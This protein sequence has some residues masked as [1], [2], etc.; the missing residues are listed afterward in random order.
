MM[1]N[2]RASGLKLDFYTL[3]FMVEV[4]FNFVK[5]FAMAC[6]GPRPG[7]SFIGYRSRAIA[8][9]QLD[10]LPKL[11]TISGRELANSF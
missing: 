3:H 2:D 8:I 6:S 10:L 7:I 11:M 5:V 9:H 1:S 4:N